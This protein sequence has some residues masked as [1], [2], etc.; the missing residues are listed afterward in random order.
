MSKYSV[1]YGGGSSVLKFLVHRSAHSWCTHTQWSQLPSQQWQSGVCGHDHF[2]V[3]SVQR[4]LICHYC[5]GRGGDL[6]PGYRE[7]YF[8]HSTL[9]SIHVILHYNVEE[10]NPASFPG[11]QAPSFTYC[12]WSHTLVMGMAWEWGYSGPM[13]AH[14]T[15]FLSNTTWVMSS[16]N[17]S[18]ITPPCNLISSPTSSRV[19]AGIACVYVCCCVVC[20][21]VCFGLRGG[22]GVGIAYVWVGVGGWE[23]NDA[24]IQDEYTKVTE[25]YRAWS[26]NL[27][28]FV[29]VDPTPTVGHTNS[30]TKQ[31]TQMALVVIYSN[32][33]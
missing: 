13:H 26:A 10:A 8:I 19:H 3:S 22:S 6:T 20:V 2:P 29:Q 33:Q 28:I 17:C 1:H 25:P 27:T 4:P 7:V 15:H 14:C 9:D 23:S 24:G 32:H 30:G 21:C 11:S 31:N 16:L 5:W 12:K 18:T